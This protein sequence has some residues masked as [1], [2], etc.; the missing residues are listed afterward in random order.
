MNPKFRPWI[1]LSLS[2]SVWTC[3][4]LMAIATDL[5][6]DGCFVFHPFV[7]RQFNDINE[8]NQ[9]AILLHDAGREE[10]VLQVRYEGPLTQFGWLIPVPARPEIS[11]ASM[12]SFYELSRFTQEFIHRQ[13]QPTVQ[14]AGAASDHPP[15]VQV[16]EYRTVGAYDVAVLATE[17]TDSLASWL[18][19]N[20]FAFRQGSQSILSEYLE[21]RWFII[22]LRVHLEQTAGQIR[23]AGPPGE[24]SQPPTRP[25]VSQAL[26][27]GELHPIKIAFETINCIFPLKISAVNGKASEVLLYVLSSEPLTCADLVGIVHHA[28]PRGPGFDLPSELDSSFAAGA[29]AGDSLP[30]CSADLLRLAH[31]KWA[32][33]KFLRVFRPHQMQDLTFHSMLALLRTNLNSWD[34]NLSYY[35]RL[36]IGYFQELA[37]P[38]IPDLASSPHPENRSVSCTMLH[39]YPRQGF[40]DILLTL[41]DD[42]DF[43]VRLQACSAAERYNDSRVVTKLLGLLGDP[44][45][46]ISRTAALSSGKLGLRDPRVIAALI[47]LLDDQYPPARAQAQAA[48]LRTTGHKFQTTREGHEWWAKNQASFLKH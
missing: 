26:R 30:K 46:A 16:I 47:V 45:E 38:L 27:T 20:H 34:P 1:A 17:S 25:D 6:S 11:A 36:R 28:D 5:H 18:R 15:P 14:Y 2:P 29:I 32:F 37:V 43:N 33:A 21:K 10:M 42:P 48:L 3:L 40:L 23:P 31:R 13:R 35:A 39:T 9:K 19:D 12:A 41:M 7:W 22:A 8:P 24:S 44:D 4:T